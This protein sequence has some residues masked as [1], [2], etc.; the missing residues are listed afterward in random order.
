MTDVTFVEVAV[1]QVRTRADQYDTDSENYFS[2]REDEDIYPITVSGSGR[3][4]RVHFRLD[5]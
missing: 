5:F 2:D 1:A 3:P 4:I